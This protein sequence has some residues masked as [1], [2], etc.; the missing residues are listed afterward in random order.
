M[1]ANPRVV[2]V[3]R[4]GYTL[5]FKQR[6]LL[7]RFHLVQSGYANPIKNQFLKEAYSR[8]H[9]Q[10]GSREGGCQVVSGILQP[11]FPCPQTK[12]KMEA[13][14]GSKSV[15]LIPQYQYFQD[16]NPGNNPVILADRE[17]VT[18]LDFSDAYFHTP[19][20]QM[21]QKYLRFFLYNQTF[22]FTALPFG[23]AT[24]PLEFTKVVKEL[25]LM[26]QA[27]GIRIHKY[28]DNWLLRA[29]CPETCPQHT[30][31]LLAFASS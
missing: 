2:S 19:I 1:G 15:E 18:S 10:V 29:P 30:Q 9:K 31:T 12:Q 23:L 5:S 24:A 11:P 8:S 7:T 13:N 14:L 4:E 26:A 22:Q 20:N 25:K 28:L 6:P 21:S 16:G 17:W 3:L 27:R